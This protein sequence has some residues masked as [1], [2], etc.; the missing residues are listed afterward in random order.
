MHLLLLL[1]VAA[2]IGCHCFIAMPDDA[3][4]EKAQLLQALGA[5]MISC[6]CCTEL[7]ISG[8]PG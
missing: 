2:A 7:C 3:A 6:V 8:C 1:Q 4:V 5:H